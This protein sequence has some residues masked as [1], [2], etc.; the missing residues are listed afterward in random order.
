MFLNFLLDLAELAGRL[1][2]F[3]LCLVLPGLF[4]SPSGLAHLAGGGAGGIGRAIQRVFPLL[5]FQLFR[6]F[7][8]S[9]C[10]RVCPLREGSLIPSGL[11][12]VGR[13]ERLVPVLLLAGELLRFLF[14]RGQLTLEGS[15]LEQLS[16]PFQRLPELLLGLAQIL[17]RGSGPFPIQRLERV[18]QLGE[19]LAKL[20]AHRPVQLFP[21]LAKPLQEHRVGQSGPLRVGAKLVER[22]PRRLGFAEQ[23]FLFFRHR[24]RLLGAFEIQ[25]ARRSRPPR[26]AL[27]ALLHPAEVLRLPLGLPALGDQRVQ[28]F[29]QLGRAFAPFLAKLGTGGHGDPHLAGSTHLARRGVVA[30]PG[31]HDERIARLELEQRRI[32][33]G[34]QNGAVEPPAGKRQRLIAQRL[35]LSGS[36]DPALQH[37]LHQRVVVSGIDDHGNRPRGR[38][39]GVPGG[40]RDL[41]HRHLVRHNPHGQAHVVGRQRAPVCGPDHQAIGA[42]YRWGQAAFETGAPDPH[43]EP[44]AVPLPA[45]RLERDGRL[46]LELDPASHWQQQG[47]GAERDRFILDAEVSRV[48][49]DQRHGG[50]ERGPPYRHRNG[51]GA[52]GSRRQM[53]VQRFPKWPDRSEG[54]TGRIHR[55]VLAF[56]RRSR[57]AGPQR[58]QLPTRGGNRE[59]HRI[60]Q[61]HRGAIRSEIERTRNQGQRFPRLPEQGCPAAS[62]PRGAQEQHRHHQDGQREGDQPGESANF[63]LECSGRAARHAGGGDVV[64]RGV[65]S[66]ARS[67]RGRLQESQQG[68]PP[69]PSRFQLGCHSADGEPSA[70]ASQPDQDQ[71]GQADPDGPRHRDVE[72]G[73]QRPEP[74]PPAGE[75]ERRDEHRERGKGQ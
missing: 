26:G 10:H 69:P 32:R 41:D 70:G 72:R 29:A 53:G 22:L 50:E 13:P 27:V 30:G 17:D 31:R 43:R 56:P 52:A 18:L 74:D 34:R 61:V 47:I 65:Q 51:V 63:G 20:G 44:G 3:L 75:R 40:N 58:Y 6:C 25:L 1:L 38:R 28:L 64:G 57:R 2:A 14:Q 12:G 59:E 11:G 9:G 23:R 39:D 8:E 60:T 21:H 67:G 4:R 55:N 35:G 36:H 37:D 73:S 49:G 45:G 42:G 19:L 46:A 7:A 24:L 48:M 71:A 62:R 15:S 33:R 54:G 68:S 16:T 5:I 66:A